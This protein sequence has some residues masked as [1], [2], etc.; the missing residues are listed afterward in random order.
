MPIFANEA[1]KL[2]QI[3]EV[4]FDIEKD[5]QKLVEENLKTIFGI[6]FVKSEFELNGLRLDSLGFDLESNSFVIIEYKR[7]KNSS[8]IDQGYAY[9]SLLLNNKAE[10]VLIHNENSQKILK[11]DDVDWS[12]S[13][14]IFISPVFTSYQKLAIGFKDLPIELW[15]VK[16]YSNKTI[17]FNQIQSPEKSESITKISSKSEIVRSVSKEIKLY[18]EDFHLEYANENIKTLYKELKDSILSIGL[19][20]TVKPKKKYIGFYRKTIF[21]DL[22]IQK[23]SLKLCLNMKKGTLNDHK[24]VARDV[25]QV[26]H[27]GNGDYQIDMKNAEDIRYIV[28]LIEQS[29]VKN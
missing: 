27:W 1:G 18:S 28:S 4:P 12:Q 7:D 22:N 2:V 19:D 9:L 20:I 26:G 14:V 15:E 8:V 6:D 13:K 24:N 11:K 3:S 25:S 29:Y 5:L 23:S 21:A 10:F 17:L 16:Q